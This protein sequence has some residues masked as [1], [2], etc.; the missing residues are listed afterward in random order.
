MKTFF[1]KHVDMNILAMAINR[2]KLKFGVVSGNFISMAKVSI[3]MS[4]RFH[5]VRLSS[6]TVTLFNNDQQKVKAT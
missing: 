4:C 1:A 3:V 5:V 6:K 2:I